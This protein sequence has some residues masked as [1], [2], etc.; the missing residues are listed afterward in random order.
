VDFRIL[1][2]LEVRDG[3]REVRLRGGKQ[4]A[5]LALL[6]VHANRTLAIDRI[7]DEL[8]GEEVPETAQ[9]MVQIYVS[10]LRKLLPSGTLHTRPPGYMLAL[11][12]DQLDLNRFERLVAD[13]TA[14]LEAGRAVEA[15]GGFRAALELW[16]GPALAEFAMEPF[17]QPEAARLEELRVA[18]LERRLEA[19]LRLGR[20][21]DVAGELE[22]LVARYP[23]REGLRR[24]QLL[25][26]YRSGRQAEAL[27]AYQHARRALADQ[28]G[29]EPS[30]TLRELERRILRQDLSL[31]LAVAAPTNAPA[32]VPARRSS[33]LPVL[34]DRELIGAE[35]QFL[36]GE[37]DFPSRRTLG[38]TNLPVVS[39]PLVGRQ[40][41]LEEL[42]AMV[43]SG[44][45]LL[46]LTGPGGTGK[47]RLALEVAA[48]L[49]GRLHDGVFWVSLAGLADPDLLA[50]EVAQTIGAPDDLTGF[51]R[52]RELLLFLDNFEH[53]LD[54]APLVSGLLGACSRLRVLVTSRAPL[55]VAGEQEYRLEPLPQKEAAALFV[56]RA[57]A[58]GRVVAPDAT[59]KEI[60]RRLDGLPLAIE[61]AAARMKLL[62][63]ER[64]LERL[65]SALD[66]LTGGPRDA[67]ERQRTLRATIE[68][69]Y[70]L[71]QPSAC[72]LFAR[73]SVFSGA[74][75]LDAAEEVCGAELDDLATLV[76]YSL[77][78][79][80]GDDRFYMLETIGEYTLEKLREGN[81][82]DELR[83][84]H[85]AFFSALAEQAYIHRFDA[86]VEWSARLEKDHDDLRAALDWL[87]G[88]DPDRALWLVGVLGWFWLSR[89]LLREGCGRISAALAA[90]SLTG[91]LRA[92]ALTWSGALVARHGDAAAGIAQLD[93]AVAMWRELGD[94]D[95]L[96]SALDNLGWPL[97][98]D[99]DDNSRA[100]EAFEESLELRR[101]LGDA[102]GM[103]RALVGIAQVLV[104]MAE[105]AHAEAISLDLLER[106]AGD[107]RTEHF[108]YHF[109]ADCALIRGDP[110]EAGT[111]YRHSLRA[112]LA[113]GDIVET[114]FEVQGVAMSEAGAGDPRRALILAESVEAL[115]ESLGL[116]ISMAFWDALLERYLAPARASLGDE[117]DA[118]RADGRALPFDDAVA[119]ALH[120]DAPLAPARNAKPGNS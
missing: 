54:A 78:K 33:G 48:E 4:R 113:L 81:E 6:L 63:P 110:E 73:L 99:A 107:A 120:D 42:V 20:H 97:V 35:R 67:P 105:T 66:L 31:D 87:S 75:P 88:D 47:T 8:W 38:A 111:R 24:Q 9:K 39:I 34:R 43:S 70:N 1:G 51:L 71:L 100:L 59:V 108:A 103:T 46:T 74:F 83:R 18:V 22:A 19:D 72:R 30:S 60:C 61:L 5:L 14:A 116:S 101:Q 65:D 86:E 106:A 45:R 92:R 11:E 56:E 25:A 27:A 119:L 32:T 17:A 41:E 26:L 114:S 23:L 91:R 89:G 62:T 102:A 44:T 52:G 90:S 115:R 57:R 85:A 55:R 40:R 117:Y 36:L 95:E 96:A 79:P 2:P 7:V 84:R 3:D 80:I 82:E 12:P 98:Y 49:V 77:L 28:L 64:L 16:R 104:A 94:L 109:L 53:L 21:G 37:G 93:A 69:S 13:A 10:H 58:V 118:I 15:A 68:W 29:I 112:A 50:S 76:D